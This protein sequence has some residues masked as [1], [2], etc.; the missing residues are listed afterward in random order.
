MQVSANGSG[1]AEGGGG[2]GT[3]LFADALVL[4]RLEYFRAAGAG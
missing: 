1:S 2:D 4:C 3:M